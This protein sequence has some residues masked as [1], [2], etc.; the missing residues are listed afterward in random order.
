MHIASVERSGNFLRRKFFMS[1]VKEEKKT[2]P[3]DSAIVKKECTPN[4][5]EGKVVS[6]ID[7]KLVMRNKDGKEFSHLLAADAKLTC[8]GIVCKPADLKAGNQVRVTTKADDRNLA[9]CVDSLDKTDEF[10][11]CCS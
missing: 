2:A 10:A 5:F 7:N 6:M 4:T 9:T 3:H 11:E 1:T 8:D